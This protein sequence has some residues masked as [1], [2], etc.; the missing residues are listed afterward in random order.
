MDTANIMQDHAELQY[1]IKSTNNDWRSLYY[2]ANLNVGSTSNSTLTD[3]EPAKFTTMF[4]QNPILA[5]IVLIF[6]FAFVAACIDSFKSYTT[7]TTEAPNIAEVAP[8]ALKIAKMNAEERMELYNK[9]FDE[10]KRQTV[11]QAASII[12]NKSDSNSTSETEDDSSDEDPSIYLALEEARSIRRSTILTRSS[13]LSID[14]A[15]ST[16]PNASTKP[17]RRLSN[18]VHQIDS[19]DIENGKK[20]AST[21]LVHGNCVICFEDIEAGETVVWSEDKACL[22]VYHKECMVAY[23]AHK[24]RSVKEIEM[25]ENP[26][27]TCR[28]K[29]VTVCPQAK[30]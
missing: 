11:I 30:Q 19:V 28:R 5:I 18:L 26:C 25:D 21:N 16:D 7:N 4:A 6:L 8:L 27:P 9:T 20:E 23:L 14:L 15:S 24:K 2:D 3:S 12:V 29:F 13:V 17:K 22:H 1:D 10:T